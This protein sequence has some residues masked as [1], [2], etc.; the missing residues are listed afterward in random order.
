MNKILK[1]NVDKYI[2]NT[3]YQVHPINHKEWSNNENA[4]EIEQEQKWN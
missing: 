2:N 3:N 1:N 4:K